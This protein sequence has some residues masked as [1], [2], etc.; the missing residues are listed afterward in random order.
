MLESF[1]T[2]VACHFELLLIHGPFPQNADCLVSQWSVSC[3]NESALIGSERKRTA[4]GA[5]KN[6]SYWEINNPDYSQDSVNQLLMRP[7]ISWKTES[8][9]V[10]SEMVAALQKRWGCGMGE[11][12]WAHVLLAKERDADPLFPTAGLVFP[13]LFSS[14]STCW[15]HFQ[16]IEKSVLQQGSLRHRGQPRVHLLWGQSLTASTCFWGQSLGLCAKFLFD[17]EFTW[18]HRKFRTLIPHIIQW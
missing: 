5:W 7:L 10:L 6:S 9:C 12:V 1:L 15:Q 2:N 16:Y 13:G 11:C 18:T 4:N 14:V 17:G 3:G 8:I